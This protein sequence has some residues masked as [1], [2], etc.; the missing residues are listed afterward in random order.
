[1]RKPPRL[2]VL[3]VNTRGGLETVFRDLGD[4]EAS[5]HD[6]GVRVTDVLVRALLERDRPREGPLGADARLLVHPR[7]REVEVVDVRE[8]LDDDLVL[9]GL[10]RRDLGA[11]L[12]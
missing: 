11:A 2:S 12:L 8:I 3:G 10:Q 1:M 7:P 6:R 9:P 4:L 5:L